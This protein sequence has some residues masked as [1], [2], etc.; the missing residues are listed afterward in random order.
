MATQI[1]IL[2]KAGLRRVLNGQIGMTFVVDSFTTSIS[3]QVAHVR[4]YRYN[5]A[6][7]EY[8]IWSI[9]SDGYHLLT[10]D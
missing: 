1:A 3:G 6:H 8:Q 10:L 4:D 2:N 5:G 9:A 7:Y